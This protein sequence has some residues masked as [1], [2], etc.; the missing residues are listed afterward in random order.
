MDGFINMLDDYMV[1][2]RDKGIKT[3]F[4][5]GHHGPVPRARSCGMIGG[6]G[7]ND[8][9]NKTSPASLLKNSVHIVDANL[10]KHSSEGSLLLRDDFKWLIPQLSCQAILIHGMYFFRRLR[11][12]RKRILIF[13]IAKPTTSF[14][15][16]R[17]LRTRGEASHA[18]STARH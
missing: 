6:D 11:K 13:A 12:L 10:Q 17:F 4:G 2:Y 14:T 3:E 9:S 15:I 5:H 18:W 1:W 16:Q 8:E 7:I